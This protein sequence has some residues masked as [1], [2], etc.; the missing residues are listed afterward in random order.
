MKEFEICGN[1][2][3]SLHFLPTETKQQVS[4]PWTVRFII[5]FLIAHTHGGS[6]RWGGEQNLAVSVVISS[7]QIHS[8]RVTVHNVE[9]C[10]DV[11][12]MAT[13]SPVLQWWTRDS[14]L[15]SRFSVKMKH[16]A[17]MLWKKFFH[18]TKS[19]KYLTVDQCNNLSA[20][21]AVAKLGQERRDFEPARCKRKF[22]FPRGESR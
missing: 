15:S 9:C 11:A 5:P 12:V 7:H 16:I 1:Q 22:K 19:S 14:Y 6:E 20:R 2:L 3:K 21:V 13:L 8:E 4:W 10:S 18:K 17:K